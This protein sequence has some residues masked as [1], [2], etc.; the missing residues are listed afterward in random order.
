M[1][2]IA[3]ILLIFVV[4]TGCSEWLD[5]N[6]D[7]NNVEYAPIEQVLPAGISGVAYVIGG[8]YQVLGALW[9][10]HWTQAPGAS[11]YQGLDSYDINSTTM[12]N[13]FESLYAGALRDLEFVRNESRRLGEWNYYI[14]ATLVQCYTFQILVDLYDQIPFSEALKGDQAAFNPAYEE[15]QAVYDSLIVRINEAVSYYDPLNDDIEQPEA[16]DLIFQ[17][18]MDLWLEF[19]NTLKLKI[20]LRQQYAR[21]EVAEA[22]IRALFEDEE[23]EFLDQP[24]GVSIYQNQSGNRNPVYQTEYIQ[25]GNNPNLILSYTLESFMNENGDI[26]R[27]SALF[28]RPENGGDHKSLE[29]GNYN[30]GDEPSGITSASYSKPRVLPDQDIF[31]FNSSEVL[32]LQVEAMIR[33]DLE[34]HAD[35]RELY[36]LAIDRAYMRLGFTSGFEAYYLSGGPY[37]FPAEGSPLEDFIESIIRQKWLSMVNMQGIESFLEQN[38]TG[39]PVESDIPADDD[40]YISGEL[41]ISVN[42]VTSG[43]FPRRLLFPESESSTTDGVVPDVQPV[44]SNVWWDVNEENE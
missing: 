6:D 31:I 20:Y 41:T 16:E 18:N 21:P 3:G 14:I 28:N 15:G 26:S 10:Q 43:R 33:Y 27:L 35:A 30:P 34:S 17:G 24:A 22:G 44:W 23:T 38:R 9:S 25:L 29:Q 11:Q 13:A 8:R 7:P 39:Y 32:L 12:E 5:V 1:T 37:E 19:A 4:L 36:E 2:R 40:N 42:N